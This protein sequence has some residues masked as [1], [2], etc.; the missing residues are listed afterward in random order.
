MAGDGETI[1]RAAS[2]VAVVAALRAGDESVFAA[3]VDSWSPAMLRLARMHVATREAAQDVVQET[4][5]AALRGIDRFE[6]RSALR[7][8]VFRILLNIARTTGVK[9]HRTVPFSTAFG[10]ETGPTV[11]PVRFQGAGERFP[12]GWRQ[13]P[14]PWSTPEGLALAGEARAVIEH[15]VATL[16]E[17]QRVVIELRDVHGY[18]A[19]EVCDLLDVSPGNQRVLL[20]RARAAV[21][22]DLERYFTDPASGVATVS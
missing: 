10:D 2:D 17:R 15:S 3:L 6:G 12:G 19:D 18:V 20:H 21:R 16:P 4:W 22:R 9:E 5:I 13:F 11:D 7:T 8:W 1:A 14:E